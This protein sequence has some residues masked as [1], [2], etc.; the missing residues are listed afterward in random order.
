MVTSDKRLLI[1]TFYFPPDLSAGS[2]RMKA[3]ID[4]LRELAPDMA[5]DVITTAPNRYRSFQ[6]PDLADHQDERLRIQRVTLPVHRSGMVDQ[7]RAFSHFGLEAAR[8]ASGKKYDLVFASSGRLMTAVIAAWIAA[9]AAAPL[10]LDIRDIFVDTI[11]HMLPKPVLLPLKPLLSLAERWAVGRAVHVNLV[12]PG[13]RSYFKERYPKQSFSFFTN[14]VDEEFCSRS[15]APARAARPPAQPV[16]IVYAGNM[17]EGQGLHGIIPGLAKGLRDRAQFKLIGDGG[18]RV[19]LENAVRQGGLNNVS[20]IPPMVR[21]SLIEEY[22]RADVL[23][24]HLN[25]YDAFEKVLPSKLFEYAAVG[26]PIWA[27][28]SGYVG[29]FIREEVT[30]AVVFPPCDEQEALRVFARLEVRDTPRPEF[31]HKYARTVIMRA[32][33]TDILARMSAG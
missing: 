11:K 5:I 17:G 14:G 6:A 19:Q 15:T 2:F 4:S 31:V 9:S 21:S 3:L 22:L 1:V 18:R 28:V 7:T 8:L 27:G 12:S 33:A 29:R 16:T 20:I 25:D 23:F 13:F 30:N 24:L 10:Y 26:K 32:M